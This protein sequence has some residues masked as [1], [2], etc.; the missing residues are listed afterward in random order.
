MHIRIVS[1]DIYTYGAMVIG[2]VLRDHGYSVEINRTLEAG[3]DD[4]VLLSLYS[5]MHLLDE[6]VQHFVRNHHAAGGIC[7]VGGPVSA[8]PEMILGELPVDA[9]ILGEGEDTVLRVL[10]EGVNGEIPG[11]AY[12][13]DDGLHIS[14]PDHI[15]SVEHPLPL[16]PKDI[17]SQS[18][19][20]A[21]VYIETHRGCIGS[22]TF[23][24]VPRFFGRQIRSR[25]IDAILREVR[26]FKKCGAKRV[27]ISGG[28]GSLYQYRD[29]RMD[30]GA[31]VRLL[32]GIAG[33]MGPRNVSAPDIRV[34][35]INDEILE[36][37]RKYTIGWLFFGIESGSDRVLRDM[38]KGV[39]SRQAA[40]AIEECRGH[41]LKVAGS[42]IVGYPTET[43]KEFEETKEFIASECLDDVFISI[44]EP[45][46]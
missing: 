40:D 9:V 18:V 33:I 32:E 29:G 17:D 39:T 22:C 3:E 1:P 19:R 27:A 14:P 28:T 38:G 36:A 45:I 26:E 21:N 12:R 31:F 42:F 24:Q 46:P 34:D 6:R 35:C 2:G 37:I 13:E 7:Y 5:T 25:S 30:T 16:I 15:P 43:E 20:G 8:Y 23:C 41:G 11:I 10:Q 4:T 44:A